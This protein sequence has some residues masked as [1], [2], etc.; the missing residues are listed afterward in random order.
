M[1][2]ST[3]P[4]PDCKPILNIVLY[5]SHIIYTFVKTML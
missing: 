5:S 1:Y 3:L 4:Q 2:I